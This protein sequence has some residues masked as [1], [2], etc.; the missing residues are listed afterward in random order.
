MVISSR[1]KQ[2]NKPII[3]LNKIQ[4]ETRGKL[5][6]RIKENYLLEVHRCE[7]CNSNNFLSLAEKDRYGLYCP[8]V[9]CKN[10]GLVQQNPRMNQEAYNSFY[11][12]EY[13]KLYRQEILIEEFF[14]FQYNRGEK[15]FQYLKKNLKI[16]LTNLKILE[17]GTGAGGILK[18]FKEQKNKVFGI[19]LDSKYV[20]FGKNKYNLNLKVGALNNTTIPWIPDIVVYSHV[21]EH[22]LNPIE[23][24]IKLKSLISENSYIYILKCLVLKILLTVM[25]QIF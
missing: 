10:C 18:Y 23:E 3:K 14:K 6:G 12:T 21:L 24:L 22:L 20:N 25:E 13:S 9:I 5:E 17:V 4:L 15:I 19:D 11:E 7:I 1:F 8:I 16:N 2:D